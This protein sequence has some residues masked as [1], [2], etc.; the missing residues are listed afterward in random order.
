MIKPLLLLFVI[1]L[2]LVMPADPMTSRE[3]PVATPVLVAEA[4][5]AGVVVVR[6]VVV[7]FVTATAGF[8]ATFGDGMTDDETVGVSVP[9]FPLTSVVPFAIGSGPLFTIAVDPVFV[10]PPG[11]AA[12]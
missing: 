9:L 6:V 8:D 5:L 3:T 11:P 1:V 10:T 7:L 2:L 12:N 4:D